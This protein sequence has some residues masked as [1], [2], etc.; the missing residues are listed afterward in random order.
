M[1]ETVLSER[2]VPP[3]THSS[4]TN[5]IGANKSLKDRLANMVQKP[6]SATGPAPAPAPDGIPNGHGDNATQP[7]AVPPKSEESGDKEVD[8][9]AKERAR[10]EEEEEVGGNTSLPA[11]PATE[12]SSREDSPFPSQE[13]NDFR[14]ADGMTAAGHG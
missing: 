13:E 3:P 14:E 7:P 5:S 11:P 9:E 6:F 12:G 10:E 8:P 1:L 2:S 4:G